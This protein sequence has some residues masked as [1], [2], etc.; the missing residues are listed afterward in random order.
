VIG[1]VIALGVIATGGFAVMAWAP[2]W[3]PASRAWLGF[4]VLLFSIPTL[5]AAGV[6]AAAL[7][8]PEEI[9]AWGWVWAGL[10]AGSLVVPA[11]AM[12]SGAAQLFE[13]RGVPAAV[14]VTLQA[15]VVA[16][17]FGLGIAWLFGR[18]TRVAGLV[19]GAMA[20]VG[21]LVALALPKLAAGYV[22]SLLWTP[23][24]ITLPLKLGER[25]RSHLA[26]SGSELAD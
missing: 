22:F 25:G 6:A 14:A 19:A 7:W 12:G 1:T 9:D 26:A 3:N 16:G 20:L 4:Y 23:L 18:L 11:M 24:A 15:L 5:L 2:H 21:I 8:A 13:G 17:G 10:A